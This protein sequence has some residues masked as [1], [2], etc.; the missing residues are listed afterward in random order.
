M[1]WPC[2]SRSAAAAVSLRTE[3]PAAVAVAPVSPA[4]SAS[5]AR[6][7]SELQ[8]P[9]L[10][11]DVPDIQDSRF[12]LLLLVSAAGLAL[13]LT[14][15]RPP[16]PVTV[17]FESGAMR[18]RRRGGHNELLGKA[19]GIGKRPVLRVVD[20]TAGLGRDAWVLAD[21]GCRVVMCERHALIRCLLEDGLSRVS[22]SP[23]S[24]LI[25][26]AARMRL[27][28]GDARDLDLDAEGSDVI[29]LDPMY[30]DRQ[31]SAAVKKEMALFQRL[32]SGA[33]DEDEELLLWALDQAVARVVIKRPPKASPLGGRAP[34]H[35]I[36]GKAVRY[37]VH[38]LRPLT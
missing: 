11:G 3:N 37:D 2:C 10:Q 17:D 22:E 26:T 32:L 14:G 34:S 25:E 8:L 38:V 9:L 29:Y 1:T 12:D 30:P 20:A 35:T 36:R 13:Q 31:K 7:A 24:P 18:H 16:G 33:P 19:V 23:D 27:W 6:L 28:P 21:L 5:A 4:Q 15:I